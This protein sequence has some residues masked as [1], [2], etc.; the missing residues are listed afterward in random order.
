MANTADWGIPAPSG[1]GE[2]HEKEHHPEGG[3]RWGGMG[4]GWTDV[5]LEGHERNRVS[6]AAKPERERERERES[7][8]EREGE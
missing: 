3:A 1:I 5:R 7:E 4:G 8:S 2:A 6:S